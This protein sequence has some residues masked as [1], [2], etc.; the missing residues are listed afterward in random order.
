MCRKLHFNRRASIIALK[1]ERKETQ[2]PFPDL[3]FFS[4][5]SFVQVLDGYTAWGCS[6]V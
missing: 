6:E 1:E 3:L 2:I 4:S 5:S